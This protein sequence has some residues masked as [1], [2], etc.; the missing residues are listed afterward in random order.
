MDKIVL[1]QVNPE[2]IYKYIFGVSAMRECVC[3]GSL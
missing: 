2:Y 1:P 3:M